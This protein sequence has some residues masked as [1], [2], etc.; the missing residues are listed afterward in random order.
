MGAWDVRSFD[1]DSACD[2]GR[3]LVDRSD[4]GLLAAALARVLASS[5]EYLDADAACEALAAAEVVAR[6]RGRWGPRNTYTEPVDV[7]VQANPM[8]P[9]SE[10]IEQTVAA[11]DRVLSE[12]S[13]LLDLWLESDDFDRWREAVSDLRARVSDAAGTGIP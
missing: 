6:L 7:W 5:D 1:N 11:I 3:K 12:P 2:W 4:S 8:E 9:G 13:E 10:L